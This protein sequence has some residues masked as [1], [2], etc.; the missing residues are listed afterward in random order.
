[1]VVES[2]VR[3]LGII[4]TLKG[5]GGSVALIGVGAV[6]IILSEKFPTR[7]A[8]NIGLL[9]GGIVG[10][11]GVYNLI[12]STTKEPPVRPIAGD[13]SI[14]PNLPMEGD[15]LCPFI[16]QGFRATYTNVT[17]K[18]LVFDATLD[19]G[20]QIGTQKRLFVY[21]VTVDPQELKKIY[22]FTYMSDW[23]ESVANFTAWDTIGGG[24]IAESGQV[25]FNVA[26]TDQTGGRCIWG[27]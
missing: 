15:L 10:G 17:G 5:V 8:K 14:F 11:V 16:V 27:R 25:R 22:F 4:D 18:R 21:G 6:I 9:T 19:I 13:I 3:Q 26:Y 23:G 7:T 20:P 2:E 24:I 1:M 12:R